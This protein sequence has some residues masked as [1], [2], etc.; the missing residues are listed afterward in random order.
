MKAFLVVTLSALAAA[1]A[2]GRGKGKEKTSSAQASSSGPSTT[3]GAFGGYPSGWVDFNG[4][5]TSGKGEMMK[6]MMG[7][8]KPPSEIS[9][10]GGSGKYKAKVF[11]DPSL[12]G[13]TIYAPKEAPV[14]K[15]LPLLLWGNGG[16]MA[17]G[18][19]HGNVLTDISS[20]GYVVIANG[21]ANPPSVIFSKNTDMFDAALW[22]ATSG[23]KYNIDV[24]RVASAGQSCGGMQAYTAN[25]TPGIKTTIIFN[26]GLLTNPTLLRPKLDGALKGTILYMEGGTSD[27]GY[28]NVSLSA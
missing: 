16:C 24:T 4:G 2:G 26:S 20:H 3:S 9:K 17:L 11:E 28:K 14:G 12:S 23:A 18:Q 27:V 25:Q 22:A 15:K 8:M 7:N 6:K 10:T 21:A 13:H 19:T 5:D 1:Q